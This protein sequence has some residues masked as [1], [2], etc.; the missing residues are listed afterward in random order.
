[1][2]CGRSRGFPAI[3]GPVF[4]SMRAWRYCQ[5][6]TR[7]GSLARSDR[8]DRN[9]RPA[10]SRGARLAVERKM[11]RRFS[12]AWRAGQSMI[13][14]TPLPRFC[15]PPKRVLRKP[16]WRQ[17]AM[18]S[19]NWRV[20]QA[21]LALRP[22]Q[23]EHVKLGWAFYVLGKRNSAGRAVRELADDLRQR[24]EPIPP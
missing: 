12:R 1:M 15:R 13:L 10:G 11:R 14:H 17:F 19:W 23:S 22:A 24:L 18:T 5:C 7:I 21:P 3:C 2:D 6:Y 16:L 20:P 8:T 4:V 9:H